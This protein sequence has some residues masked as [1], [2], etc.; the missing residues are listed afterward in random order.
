MIEHQVECTMAEREFKA[1]CRK[2]KIEHQVECTMAEREF[3]AQDFKDRTSSRMYF[4]RK[5]V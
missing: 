2:L 1:H 5:G 3:K 4:G